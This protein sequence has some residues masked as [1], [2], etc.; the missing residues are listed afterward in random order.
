MIKR[1]THTKNGSV[2]THPEFTRKY[3]QYW[4]TY[5]RKGLRF[6]SKQK[7]QIIYLDTLESDGNF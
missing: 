5:Q 2:N 6:E 1:N 7:C 4:L 3:K